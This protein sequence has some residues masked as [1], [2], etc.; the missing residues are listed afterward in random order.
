MLERAEML[1]GNVEV[2]SSRGEGTRIRVTVPIN[3]GVETRG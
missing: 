3:K 2:E 1:G